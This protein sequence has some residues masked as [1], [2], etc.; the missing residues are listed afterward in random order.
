MAG[1][2]ICLPPEFIT[3]LFRILKYVAQH[4]TNGALGGRGASNYVA[5]KQLQI[6]AKLKAI[7]TG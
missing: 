1:R 6:P 3:R 5:C 4:C 2:I 7:I